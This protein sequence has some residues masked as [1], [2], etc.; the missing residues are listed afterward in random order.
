[1]VDSTKRTARGVATNWQE[2]SCILDWLELDVKN[3]NLIN[4]GGQ[5]DAKGVVAGQKL[6]KIDAY[7]QLADY[8]NL[9]FHKK[10]DAKST[11][12]RFRS[13]LKK[14]KLTKH[15]FLDVS[16]KKFGLTAEEIASGMT[17]DGKLEKLCYGFKR[18]DNLYGMR[19]NVNPS[20]TFESLDDEDDDDLFDADDDGYDVVENST[21]PVGDEAQG[22]GT[23]GNE[24]AIEPLA[25]V[26]TS[27]A[28]SPIAAPPSAVPPVTEPKAKGVRE[29]QPIR[30]DL[31][32]LS[33][34]A[35]DAA[36]EHGGKISQSGG[37]GKRGRD[38]STCFTDVKCSELEFKR[39]CY[40]D[41]REDKRKA[42]ARVD[43]DRKNAFLIKLVEM[44]KT[45]EDIDNLMRRFN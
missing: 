23:L 16:G 42:E 12:T 2:I 15:A 38:F 45:D 10:W 44:G 34:E 8:V 26:H 29:T 7:K 33:K 40:L 32:Q 21:S 14:Y 37:S 36:K 22:V 13:L 1:M 18:W 6:K 25:V 24:F 9:R 3:F 17:V 19:Q 35:A 28:P 41:D 30:S 27:A 5:K 11:G 31:L 4:G 39:Q 20:Y 43:A